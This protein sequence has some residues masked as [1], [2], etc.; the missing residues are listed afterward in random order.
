M[1]VVKNMTCVSQSVSREGY[2]VFIRS[3][4]HIISLAGRKEG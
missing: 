2:V 4:Q 1:V 3:N